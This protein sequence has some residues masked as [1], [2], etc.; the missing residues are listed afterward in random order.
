M[1]DSSLTCSICLEDFVGADDS[2]GDLVGTLPLCGHCFH[3]KCIQ[4]WAAFNSCPICR[5]NIGSP[6]AVL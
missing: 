2:S 4:K 6:S 1:A 5:R 3:F